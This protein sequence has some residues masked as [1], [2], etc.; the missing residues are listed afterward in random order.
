MIEKLLIAVF[1]IVGYSLCMFKPSL[2]ASAE[3]RAIVSYDGL[4]LIALISTITTATAV[5]VNSKALEIQRKLPA[6]KKLQ[7]AAK[8]LRRTMRRNAMG[9]FYGFFFAAVSFFVLNVVKPSC[10]I[11]SALM[12][13]TFLA[14]LV[15]G[16]FLVLD[17]YRVTFGL[18]E[19]EAEI[20]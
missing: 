7:D 5:T 20:K 10:D 14:V 8:D 9:F 13:M 11:L 4:A 12:V 18:L 3:M 17:V 2:M 15:L 1:L 16:F 6:G 19:T